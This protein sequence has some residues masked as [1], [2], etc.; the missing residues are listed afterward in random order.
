MT[1]VLSLLFMVILLAW[2]VFLGTCAVV[3]VLA[4]AA[5]AG[6]FVEAVQSSGMR[7]CGRHRS[8]D[9]QFLRSVGIRP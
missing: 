6:R 8:S 5:V 3:G 2:L 4:A 9:L 1:A 7:W